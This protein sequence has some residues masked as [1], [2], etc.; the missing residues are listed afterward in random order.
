MILASFAKMKPLPIMFAGLL[1]QFRNTHTFVLSIEW[2][3]CSYVGQNR[4]EDDLSNLAARKNLYPAPY[5][6]LQYRNFKW[7]LY[8]IKL[9]ACGGDTINENVSFNY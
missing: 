9:S 8:Y 3:K 7:N 6:N 5:D 1:P 4:E 2:N